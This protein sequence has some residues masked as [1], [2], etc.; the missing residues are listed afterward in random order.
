[1]IPKVARQVMI[2][3]TIAI[4][5]IR[6]FRSSSDSDPFA[7]VRMIGSTNVEGSTGT[8]AGCWMS[9]LTSV[10]VFVAISRTV[11]VNELDRTVVARNS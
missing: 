6:L 10:K 7:R 2:A 8:V 9:G 1:M 3:D 11:G 4:D 5:M